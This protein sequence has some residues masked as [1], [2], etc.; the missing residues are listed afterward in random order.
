MRLY[1]HLQERV[2]S[3][4]V[5]QHL[6]LL[7]LSVNGQPIAFHQTFKASLHSDNQIESI[8]SKIHSAGKFG[9]SIRSKTST[10]ISWGK[11]VQEDLSLQ[12]YTLVPNLDTFISKLA[13]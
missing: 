8:I 2:G 12:R 10:Y 9:V 7:G 1:I 4:Y 3:M 13:S 6:I 5:Y 11:L